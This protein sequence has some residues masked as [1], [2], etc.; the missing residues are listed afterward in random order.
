MTR[1]EEDIHSTHWY[2]EGS[3]E[4]HC[5]MVSWI[6]EEVTLKPLDGSELMVFNGSFAWRV[7][8]TK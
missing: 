2:Y 1:R 7:E 3:P 6:G 5:E 8:S 4:V